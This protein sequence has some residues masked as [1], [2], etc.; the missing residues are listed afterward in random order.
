MLEAL[1]V[2]AAEGRSIGEMSLDPKIIRYAQADN[3]AVFTTIRPDG[4]PVTQPMWVDADE[5][6][7]L[8]N[9]EKHRRKFRNVQ[10]DPRV[11][12]TILDKDDPY[13][14]VEV[15]GRVVDVVEGAEARRHIDALSRKY[16]GHDYPVDGVISERVILRIQPFERSEKA[17]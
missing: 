12:V 8:I 16:T 15:R 5:D 10:D 14:Y 2:V 3:F 17:D 4:H 13:A 1:L 7:V 11:T 9:T 6:Y